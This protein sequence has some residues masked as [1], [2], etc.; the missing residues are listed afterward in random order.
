[1][2]Y[3]L[4]LGSNLKNRAG[5]LRKAVNLLIKQ[6]LQ[7]IRSSSIYETQPTDYTDQPWFLNQVIEVE[8][9]NDSKSLLL[10]I[11][12]I[13][14]QM[15]RKKTTPK[16]PRIID[17]DILLNEMNIVKTNKLIIPHPML[18][19]RNFVL[20]PLAEIAPDLNHP[21]LG[22]TIE[23]LLHLCTD[24]SRVIRFGSEGN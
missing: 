16:G 10:L 13:E 6:G 1:M 12:K 7:I 5:N 18:E 4:S 2:K 21:V 20:I 17:I 23:E 24:Y 8:Y 11:K 14:K 3:F 15:G 19:K 22:N 9:N